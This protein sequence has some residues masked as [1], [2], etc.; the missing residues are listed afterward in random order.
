MIPNIIPKQKIVFLGD[1]NVG[2]TSIINRFLYD[3]FDSG[4]KVSDKITCN[5]KKMFF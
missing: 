4:E 2:K 3:K 5:K 1:Q